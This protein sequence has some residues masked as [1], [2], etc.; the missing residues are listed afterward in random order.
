M[1]RWIEQ[2][3]HAFGLFSHSIEEIRFG[4]ITSNGA[5]TP[6]CRINLE[7]HADYRLPEK[8]VLVSSESSISRFETSLDDFC[9][10]IPNTVRDLE[11]TLSELEN[12][13]LDVLLFRRTVVVC[14]NVEGS[15]TGPQVPG[16]ASSRRPVNCDRAPWTS[17]AKRCSFI[18]CSIFRKTKPYLEASLKNHSHTKRASLPLATVALPLQIEGSDRR[19]FPFYARWPIAGNTTEKLQFAIH[20]K[21]FIPSNRRQVSGMIAQQPWNKTLFDVASCAWTIAFLAGLEGPHRDSNQAD[22]CGVGADNISAWLSCPSVVSSADIQELFRDWCI[23]RLRNTD[24]A[25][26]PVSHGGVVSVRECFVEKDHNGAGGAI[27]DLSGALIPRGQYLGLIQRIVSVSNLPAAVNKM[28]SSYANILDRDTIMGRLKQLADP[29][30]NTDLAVRLTAFPEDSPFRDAAWIA[31][32]FEFLTKGMSRQQ[33]PTQMELV[34][35]FLEGAPLMLQEGDEI[36]RKIERMSGPHS[37][38][39]P[40]LKSLLPRACFPSELLKRNGVVDRLP[41][42]CIYLAL[43]VEDLHHLPG[44][45]I[46]APGDQDASSGFVEQTS[47]YC[48]WAKTFL[49]WLADSVPEHLR[50]DVLMSRLFPVIPTA[51]RKLVCGKDAQRVID[52]TKWDQWRAQIEKALMP[53]TDGI[54]LFQEL[55]NLPMPKPIR[56]VLSGSAKNLCDMLVQQEEISSKVLFNFF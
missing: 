24:A 31:D 29:V 48:D 44:G 17:D 13:G 11:N 14:K 54:Y 19:E 1:K 52:L 3:A 49:R 30:F 28:I 56:S 43:R 37:I 22:L 40:R 36:L 18:V 55:P 10:N 7:S 45:L 2:E 9:R 15:G 26:I 20:A 12:P 39:A 38:V 33:E 53:A 16:T 41:S 47:E 25:C 42:A 27:Q 21:W 6:V 32:M 34:V 4:K 35:S 23:F 8:A 50:K 51:C 46:F 5:F